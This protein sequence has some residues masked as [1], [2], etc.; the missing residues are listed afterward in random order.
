MKCGLRA[1]RPQIIVLAERSSSALLLEPL[2]ARRRLVI[3]V[4]RQNDRRAS[5]E[6]PCLVLPKAG[7]ARSPILLLLLLLPLPHREER[8]RVGV[9]S[10]AFR[11][12]RALCGR[13]TRLLAR[14]RGYEWLGHYA[15]SQTSLRRS[16]DWHRSIFVPIIIV[17]SVGG[18][19]A[20][21]KM[22]IKTTTKT[23]HARRKQAPTPKTLICFTLAGVTA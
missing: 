4:P 17:T 1:K 23:A 11:T 9:R 7:S 12:V 20:S 8:A 21:T 22:T 10:Q 2:H 14:L 6:L 13:C 19:G 15:S 18:R 5:T 16:G 3:Q